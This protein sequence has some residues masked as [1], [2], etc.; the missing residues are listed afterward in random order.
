[1]KEEKQLRDYM[2][3]RVLSPEGKLDYR[4]FLTEAILDPVIQD[5]ISF[6][7]LFPKGEPTFIQCLKAKNDNEALKKAQ[8]GP[9]S[10]WKWSGYNWGPEDV[11]YNPDAIFAFYRFLRS[12]GKRIV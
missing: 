10:N 8:E 9:E 12:Q 11:K 5:S 4:V 3:V 6:G 1:V 7:A 2:I